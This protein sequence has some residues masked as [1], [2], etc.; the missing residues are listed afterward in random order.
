MFFIF[1]KLLV[2]FIYPL[3]WILIFLVASLF[4]KKQKLKR[5]A[6]IVAAVLFIIFS[7]PFLFNRFVNLWDI[8][9]TTLKKTGPYSSAIVLGGF[10][11]ED[12]K[13]N[14]YFNWSGD[15]FIEGVKLFNTGKVSHILISGGNGTLINDGFEEADW[16]KEQ[17]KD[18]KVPDSCVLIENHSRNTLENAAF[19]KV[20]LA[21]N[22][23]QPPYVLVTSAFH[24]R[25]S[26]AIFKKAGVD[27]V[28]YSCNYI[29]GGPGKIHLD[30][31]LPDVGIIGGWNLYIK[32]LI[33][34]FVN[35]L[36]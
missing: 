21:K 33:G 17:L 9:E 26:L 12:N 31:F 22:R 13:G 14:G 8:R 30:E 25:R 19:S 24:M 36:K 23:L 6:L 3:S 7:N 20:I 15:R 5:R 34:T 29:N 18:F 32:E 2:F 10:S 1:S 11:S 35:H 4:V 27:V 16:V 28:P